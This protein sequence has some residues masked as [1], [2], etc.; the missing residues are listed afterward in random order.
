MK[1]YRIFTHTININNG[2]FWVV[3]E[4]YTEAVNRAVEIFENLGNY[5]ENI[6]EDV[7]CMGTAYLT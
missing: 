6:I 2:Y 5:N 4:S 1:V 7:A 3:A